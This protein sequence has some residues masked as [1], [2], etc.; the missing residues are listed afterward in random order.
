MTSRLRDQSAAY[1]KWLWMLRVQN[2]SAITFI[3]IVRKK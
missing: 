1:W 2:S 3:N